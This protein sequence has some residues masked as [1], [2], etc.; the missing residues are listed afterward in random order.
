MHDNGASEKVYELIALAAEVVEIAR[1][2][3]LAG[4]IAIYDK[5]RTIYEDLGKDLKGINKH[6][7]ELKN[8]ILPLQ[9]EASNIT[10]VTYD[11]YRFS[12]IPKKRTSVI[13][14]QKN[15]AFAWLREQGL[16]DLIQPSINA[17]TL[18]AQANILYKEQGIDMPPDLFN[19]YLQPSISKTKVR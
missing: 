9:Y 6:F 8:E 19:V 12:Y 3:D 16:D 17:N 18:S 2:S 7:T 5:L 11:G 10:S 4:S 1:S 15:E 13:S 14:E